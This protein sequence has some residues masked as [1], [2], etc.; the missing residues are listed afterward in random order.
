LLRF[1]DVNNDFDN[2][3]FKSDGNTS[4]AFWTTLQPY[5]FVDMLAACYP[6]TVVSNVCCSLLQNSNNF[7]IE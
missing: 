4:N 5:A 7:C 3:N 2:S 1:S 6:S